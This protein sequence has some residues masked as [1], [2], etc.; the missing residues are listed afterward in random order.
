MAVLIAV[1]GS[2]CAAPCARAQ[3]IEPRA[4]S[5][6]PVGVNFLIA[7]YAYTQGA[8]EFAPLPVSDPHFDSPTAILAYA[9]SLDIGGK[10][11]K[12]DMS[13]PYSWLSGSA[14]ND[15]SGQTVSRQ[16]SGFG[17]PAFRLSVNLMG[18]PALT[19]QQFASYRQDLIVGVSLQV[20]APWSQYDGT[21]LVNLG[22]NRWSFK[23]ELGIS[24]ALDGWIVELMTAVTFY[25]TNTDFYNGRERA[26]DPLYQAQAHVVRQFARGIWASGDVIYYTG[27]RTTLDGRLANDLEQNWRMGATLALPIN[28]RDSIKVYASD[29]VS[30]RTQ[31]NFALFGIAW[32]HRWGAGL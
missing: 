13:A 5:N 7:G 29:G 19:P 15:L 1:A 11:A 26:T 17:D 32:Q 30:S 12:F 27:G 21:R 8:L 4:Y 14:R 2:I 23:P 28:R 16:I 25:T 3:S 18:A 22:T 24:K 20:T 6:I 9:R 31:N 10:S